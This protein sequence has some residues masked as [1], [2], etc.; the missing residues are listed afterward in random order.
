MHYWSYLWL[1]SWEMTCAVENNYTYQNRELPSSHYLVA[2]I[3]LLL[4]PKKLLKPQ[5]IIRAFA[6]LC[7]RDLLLPYRTFRPSLLLWFYV[8]SLPLCKSVW[9]LVSIS[10]TWQDQTPTTTTN[11]CSRSLV[12]WS[13][14]LWEVFIDT[15]AGLK[16]K[17]WCFLKPDTWGRHLIHTVNA[18]ITKVPM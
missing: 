13:L 6:Y 17:T 16:E 12:I 9:S 8:I 14:R 4:N 11:D 2:S 3:V 18:Q 1:K 7:S 10:R 5:T 15:G